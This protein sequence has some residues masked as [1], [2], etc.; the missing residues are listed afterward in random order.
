MDLIIEE[1]KFEELR[2]KLN[3][4]FSQI[5]HTADN[6]GCC[7]SGLVPV[8]KVRIFSRDRLLMSS[9]SESL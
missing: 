4:F 3:D 1:N 7:I 5:E 8:V 9:D 2:I 6:F